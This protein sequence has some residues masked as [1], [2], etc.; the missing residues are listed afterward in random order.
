MAAA[1]SSA[2]RP[3]VTRGGRSALV[4]RRAVHELRDPGFDQGRRA[5]RARL[6]VDDDRVAAQRQDDAGA[7]RVAQQED[8]RV[9]GR[10]VAGDLAVRRGGDDLIVGRREHGPEG[11]VAA[12]RGLGGEADREAH[13]LLVVGRAHGRIVARGPMGR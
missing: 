13:E 2:R 12:A 5:H 9:G 10:V 7:G 11:R 3:D 4:V 6:G 8:L 1:A